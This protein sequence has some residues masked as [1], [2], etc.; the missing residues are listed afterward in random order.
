D[1]SV[2]IGGAE[3]LTGAERA[4]ILSEWNDTAAEVPGETLAGLF[5][6]QVCR[7]PEA[8]AVFFAGTPVSYAELNA[9]ANRL[10]HWLIGQGVGPEKL[11]AVELPRSVEMVVAVLAVLK[12][13]GAY[14]PLDP[15]Y[16]GDRREFMLADARPVLVLDAEAMVQ[17]MS[18]F[19][20]TDPEADIAL[21]CP[22]Y[23]IY[24]S[25]STGTPKAV[26]VTH[27]GVAALAR[28]QVERLGVRPPSRVLQFAS[29]SFDVA[30]GDLC[31][32]FAA[33]AAL[34]IPESGRLS[35]EALHRLLADAEVTHV[36]LPL[37]VLRALTF[38]GIESALPR[39]ETVVA[40]GEVCPPDLAAR[41]SAGRRM[42]NAYGPTEATVCVSTS[43]MTD[44]EPLSDG[45]VPIGRPVTNTRL[46]VLDEVLRP[47]PVGVVGELY[48]S[49]AGLARGYLGRVGLTAER[50]VACP[51][52]SGV[53]M[54]RTGDLV[55][56]RADGQ[57]EFVG[58]ADEQVKVRGF[59]IEPGEVE[60]LLTGC[61]GVRQAAV[62][63]REDVP[64]DHRLVA[65]VVPDGAAAVLDPAV[66]T[67][68]LAERLPEYMVPSA[69]MV[70]D[71]L[72]LT[73]NGK[74]DRRAL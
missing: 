54:Y 22:A 58:R 12:A 3:L 66:L 59:R 49:G 43:T 2:P 17:D 32:A 56:W 18:G 4:R 27:T 61:E 40:G 63:V 33:G 74:L 50:F 5:E 55:R 41:W 14:L 72:P 7:A 9:R 26:V 65:Y 60:S 16:P 52:G 11:V 25:G 31:T 8:T 62:L 35:S 20:D 19:P 1:P 45:A 48:V 68:H 29:L 73:P 38:D 51:F 67:A 37:S 39:L 47:V 23:V 70:L 10:A 53:R 57:L 64:G 24:T 28:T 69:V 15:E 6:A 34:V 71:R 13:G 46:F 42:L 44:G 36:Q 21:T 30:F